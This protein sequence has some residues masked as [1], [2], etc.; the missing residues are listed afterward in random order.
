M[1]EYWDEITDKRNRKLID[2]DWTQLPDC[3]LSDSKK[4]EWTTY[5]Q[6]LRDIPNTLRSHSNYV[7]DEASNPYNG[8]IMNWSWPTKPST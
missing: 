5:R 7:S 4:A 1:K 6:A 3:Q 8:T 2:C